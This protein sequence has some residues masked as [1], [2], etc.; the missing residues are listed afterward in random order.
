MVSKVI[1]VFDFKALSGPVRVFDCRYQLS[2][3][4]AGRRAHQAGHIPGAIF[5]SMDEDLSG[6]TTGHNGRHPLPQASDWLNT[7]QRLGV[8]RDTEIVV[9]DDAGG[10]FAARA[11]WLMRWV[12]IQ[13]VAVLDGGW[14]AWTSAGLPIETG[15]PASLGLA[16]EGLGPAGQMPTV[17]MQEVVSALTTKSHQVI[18]ARSP[19]RFRGENETID[20][21]GGHIPGAINRCFKE[22]LTPDGRFKSA[23]ALREEWS[24]ILGTRRPE[25]LVCQ[26]GSGVTACHLLLALEIAG[27]SGASL[28]PGSWSEWCADLGNPIAVGASGH[29]Y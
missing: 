1:S 12:G 14:Q 11:W 26:C 28:Y 6:V 22:N 3:P 25:E 4:S 8:G 15:V 10:A 21:V 18:D 17:S 2:D 16:A 27:Y 13:S 19:D 9:Y 7:L 29:P 20:P 23:Q 5:L 24:K